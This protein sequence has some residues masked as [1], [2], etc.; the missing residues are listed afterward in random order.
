MSV[1]SEQNLKEQLQWRYAVK[2]FDNTKII[3]D[4]TW[5]TLEDSL[6]LTPSSYGLQPWKFFVIKSSEMKNTLLPHTYNQKQ[7]IDCSHFVVF[8]ALKQIDEKYIN[9]FLQTTADT[10]GVD[11]TTLDGYKKYMMGD[12]VTGS[13]SKIATEWATRQAYISLGNF[14]TS[15]AVLGIDTCAIEGFVPSKYDEVLNLAAEGLTSV[16]CCAAGFRS[17]EDKYATTKKV[18]FTAKEMIS[19]K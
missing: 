2:K 14:M 6:I 18:R 11:I 10:R 9:Q 19:Y 8:C 16:V 15:A 17:N 5:K 4:H 7:I 13:R 1:Y 12:L 3:P